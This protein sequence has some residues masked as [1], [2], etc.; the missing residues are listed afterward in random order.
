MTSIATI[1]GSCDGINCGGSLICG[2]EV[3]ST[4]NVIRNL[5][6]CDRCGTLF[7]LTTTLRRATAADRQVWAN[8]LGEV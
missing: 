6:L 8:A 3:E 7:S 4:S 5:A 1:T 2:A